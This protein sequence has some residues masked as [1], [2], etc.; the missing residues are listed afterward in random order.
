MKFV[1]DTTALSACLREEEGVMS[2]LARYKP[3]NFFL[4]PPTVAEIEYGIARLKDE[5]KK[6][7]LLIQQKD[8]FFHFFKV[9]PWTRKS[10]ELFGLI[11]SGLEKSGNLIDDFDVA[12]AAIAKSHDAEVLTANLVHFTRVNGLKC[13]FW[14]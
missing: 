14:E 8:K 13:L 9:L 10:S 5:S 7:R 12:I 1:L 2:F 3:G 6:K 4:V 11:K